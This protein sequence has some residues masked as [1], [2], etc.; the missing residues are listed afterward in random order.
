MLLLGI[1]FAFF[2][3]YLMS[4]GLKEGKYLTHIYIIPV[5]H[6]KVG[7][8]KEAEERALNHARNAIPLMGY[9]SC[10]SSVTNR[11]SYLGLTG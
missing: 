3:F 4:Q 5:A 2:V 8:N 11:M 6:W 10:E 9:C 1:Y 7:V